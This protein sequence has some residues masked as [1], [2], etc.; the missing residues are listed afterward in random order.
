MQWLSTDHFIR[1]KT[2]S[3]TNWRGPQMRMISQKQVGRGEIQIR[4]F[5]YY[6][7]WI[8]LFA[9]TLSQQPLSAWFKTSQN[10]FPFSPTWTKS[11]PQSSCH[12]II[13][14][15]VPKNGEESGA[16]QWMELSKVCGI[17]GHCLYIFTTVSTE[18]NGLKVS[19]SGCTEWQ[20]LKQFSAPVSPVTVSRYISRNHMLSL[21]KSW[22]QDTSLSRW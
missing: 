8:W 5:W 6:I 18:E 2:A 21:P 17:R 4:D 1:K 20:S 22:Y 19:F 3:S 7:S 14:S 11:R 12:C 10:S 15:G 9:S 16:P 13:G